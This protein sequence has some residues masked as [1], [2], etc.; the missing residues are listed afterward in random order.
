MLSPTHLSQPCLHYHICIHIVVVLSIPHAQCIIYCEENGIIVSSVR[1]RHIKDTFATAVH[2]SKKIL[3][4]AG[5]RRLY[6]FVKAKLKYKILYE[7]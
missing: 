6:Y 5:K 4:Y 3:F 2:G 1:Q 7:F